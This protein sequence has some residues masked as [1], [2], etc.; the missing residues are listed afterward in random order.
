MEVSDTISTSFVLDTVEKYKFYLHHMLLKVCDY[1]IRQNE[2]IQELEDIISEYKIVTGRE[3]IPSKTYYDIAFKLEYI[4]MK[5]VNLL[6]DDANLAVSYKK[7]R[8]LAVFCKR[9]FPTIAKYFPQAP[10]GNFLCPLT[11]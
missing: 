11:D 2:F 7:W 4:R 6:G 9:K 8:R 5:M 3:K 1:K 10:V